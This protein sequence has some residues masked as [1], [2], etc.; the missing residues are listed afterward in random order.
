M[1]TSVGLSTPSSETHSKK[2]Q[3]TSSNNKIIDPTMSE[4]VLSLIQEQVKQF[5]QSFE[6]VLEWIQQKE[7]STSSEI[8]INTELSTDAKELQEQV[9]RPAR[10]P[11]ND[12]IAAF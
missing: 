11:T 3:L 4:Y 9:S 10:A 8:I 2:R 1:H 5:K 6:K 12:S 7:K